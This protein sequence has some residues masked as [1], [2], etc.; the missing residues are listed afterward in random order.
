MLYDIGADL[1]EPTGR[2]PN[3]FTCNLF[4]SPIFALIPKLQSY[5]SKMSILCVFNN[6]FY[7]FFMCLII[8]FIS[9]CV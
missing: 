5:K 4:Q 2:V 3:I 9:V 7:I 8:Y 1:G 6:I